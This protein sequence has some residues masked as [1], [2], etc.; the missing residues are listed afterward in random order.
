MAKNKDVINM[1]DMR[2]DCIIEQQNYFKQIDKIF[3]MKKEEIERE[4][5]P[6][7]DI[8]FY[9]YYKRFFDNPSELG[10]YHLGLCKH[11]LEVTKSLKKRVLDVG[12]GF[13]LNSIYF[14]LL[15]ANVVGVELDPEKEAVFRAILKRL[16]PPLKRI[17]MRIDDALEIDFRGEQFDT[18]VCIEVIS[19]VRDLDSFLLRMNK[20]LTKGGSLYIRD[21]NN[22]LSVFQRQKNRAIWRKAELEYKSLRKTAIKKLLGKNQDAL[23]EILSEKT[24]GLY[25]DEITVAVDEYLKYG[26]ITCKVFSKS[27][28]PISGIYLEREFNPFLLETILHKNGFRSK[29]I[30]PFLLRTHRSPHIIFLAEFIRFFHPFS[31]F[32][33]PT[34]EIVAE[35]I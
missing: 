11:I 21:N 25:G 24:A 14:S 6:C 16:V 28:N 9:S 10:V 4:F 32:V 29:I 30:R 17:E 19:H 31:V 27:R 7:C 8:D 34:F 1:A 35:K 18:I 2:E 33:C 3:R 20:A 23:A 15:G 13:G 26:K 12:A 22:G 5:P